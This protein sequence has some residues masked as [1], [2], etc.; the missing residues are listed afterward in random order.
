VKVIGE[1]KPKKAPSGDLMLIELP[2]SAIEVIC[3]L[4]NWIISLGYYPLGFGLVKKG[5]RSEFEVLGLI[6]WKDGH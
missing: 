4:F 2:N 5:I 3:K 1:L 6:L